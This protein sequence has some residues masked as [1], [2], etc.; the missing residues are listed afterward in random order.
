M[1]KIKYFFN[2]H[3]LRFEKIEVP[4]KV[5]LLQTIGFIVASLAV[6]VLFLAIL[7]QYIDSPKARLL[8]RQNIA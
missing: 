5:R 2:T 1:K 7:F 6:G 4:F 3:T 8:R